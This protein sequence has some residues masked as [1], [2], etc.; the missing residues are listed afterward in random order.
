M[1]DRMSGSAKLRAGSNTPAPGYFAE[2]NGTYVI[3]TERNALRLPTYARLDL[4]ANR[5]FNG[6]RH[7][8]T[9]FAEVMN[10]F[11]RANVRFNPPSVNRSTGQVSRLFEPLIPTVPSAGIQS[12]W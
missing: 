11:N 7:R 9:L 6:S 12:E 3:S 2:R 1:S 8:L 10:V 4:R 5:T